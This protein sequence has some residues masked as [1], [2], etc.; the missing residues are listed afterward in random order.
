MKKVVTIML[1]LVLTLSLFAGCASANTDTPAPSSDAA[2]SSDTS[3]AS[4]NEPEKN[5]G[6]IQFH[7][8]VAQIM[9]HTSLDQIR[10]SFMAEMEKLGYGPDKV[11]FEYANAQADQSNLNSI[12]Q[13]FAGDEKDLIVAIATPTAQAAAAAAPNIPLVF[14]AVTDPVAAKLV[15]S[16]EQPEGIITGTSDAI[17]VDQIF[18]L[19]KQLTPDVNTVG[20]IYNMGETNSLSVIEDAKE[21]CDANGI[22]YTEA[23]VTNVNEVQQAAQSLV[24]KC[25]AIFTP[26]DNTVATAMSVLADVARQAKLPVY[27]G[28]DSMVIDGGFATVGIDYTV[29]G[30]QTAQMA[31]K[32]LE[33]TPISEIPVETLTNFGTVINKTTAEAIGVTLPED[34]L[35]SAT[36]VE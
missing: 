24:G 12:C 5:D 23:T 19:M 35:S 17:P 26:I 21:Y 13:K 31:V 9:E 30:Q 3:E 28:A 34:V 27:T 2:P 20:F 1:T 6:D 32:V 11:D 25:E 22:A 10:E 7:V 16:P 29:L 4:E 33:G 8:G 15:A 14:S 18:G 36:I